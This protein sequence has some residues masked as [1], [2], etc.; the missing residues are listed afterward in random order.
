MAVDVT[1]A[2]SPG[3]GPHVPERRDGYLPIEDYGVIGD[4]RALALVGLDGGIDWMCLP[5]LDSPS[6]FA[7][8]L[9]P[10]RGGRFALA[11]ETPFTAE[12]RYLD[13]TNV[14][15]TTF[16]TADG[17][18]RVTDAVTVDAAQVAP[19]RELVRKVEGLS[20]AVPM[21]WRF[22]PRPDYGRR[23]PELQR[24]ED[25][26]VF[27]NRDLHLG[28]RTWDAGA[29][30]VTGGSA[31]GQFRIGEGGDAL[32]SIAATNGAP[33]PLPGR[34]PI[35]RRLAETAQVWRTWVV[36][37]SYAGRWPDAVER[38][39]LAIKLL[40]DTRTGAIT[41]AGTTSLPE[42]VGGDRNYDYRF[43]WVRDLCFTLDALLAVGMQELVQAS[44]G[45]LL[46]ATAHTHPRIDPVYALDGTVVRGQEQLS[47]SGYLRTAPLHI[48]N[49]AGSQLQLGG[50]GDLLETM[51]SYA[52]A[53]HLLDA[54]TAERLADIGDLLTHI[55][56]K[57][58]SGLWEL[59]T[60][61]DYGTSK[62]S[63]WVA[64]D[65]LLELA[66]RGQVPSRHPQRWRRARDQLR[67]FIETR[68]FSEEKGS[69]LFKAGSDALDCGMLLVG[70]RRF[71]DPSGQRLNGTIDA[72]RRELHAGGPLLYRYSG[73]QEEEN[74]FLACTFWM[75]EAMAVAGRV[76][77][78]AELMDEAV[79]LA[80][81]LGLYT[82]EMEPST[83]A[84]RGNFPQAL[85]HLSLISAAASVE[86]AQT[87]SSSTGAASSRQS[88]GSPNST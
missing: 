17:V 54:E 85:T 56:P 62:L 19:W 57:Q 75:V 33:L 13:R 4:G 87:S 1:A 41:A 15:Q 25:T 18:V 42:V 68:L 81:D 58:D 60:L 61:A 40:A 27:G 30:E 73:M 2:V 50:F 86:R 44:V 72:I 12:H 6:T 38:S 29:V 88:G 22:E 71:G 34:E 23:R 5:Q 80:S 59:G 35:E 63:A 82:E 47:L 26:I 67:E 78:A 66:E 46:E 79:G 36:R 43:G 11:P 10:E 24:R 48:A 49:K 21:R 69:Y 51:C 64:F 14:L 55:W 20:G 28:L 3:V 70:R 9:D 76:D 32:L 53:G 83:H 77:Q 39:L 37:H 7:A 74:A 84:M 45:W 52:S 65:R 8:I 31:F 16:H